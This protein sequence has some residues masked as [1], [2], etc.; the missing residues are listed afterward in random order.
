MKDGLF[1][2]THL[3]MIPILLG[4]LVFHGCIFS[5]LKLMLPNS[6]AH[7]LFAAQIMTVLFQSKN[8][9]AAGKKRL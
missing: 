5:L 7:E 1:S 3:R 9:D 6:I 4:S 8:L 2:E